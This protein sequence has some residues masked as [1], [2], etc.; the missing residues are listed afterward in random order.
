MYVY[1]CNEILKAPINNISDKEMIF[2]FSK[3]TTDLKTQGF[4]PGFH[5]MDNKA[6]TEETM[7]NTEIKYQVVPLGNHRSNNTDR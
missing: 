7:T 6:Y 4:N 2:G 1:D 3:Q 5:V